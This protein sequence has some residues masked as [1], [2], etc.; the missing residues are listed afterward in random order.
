MKTTLYL[1]RHGKTEA[2]EKHVYCGWTDLPLSE[3]GREETRRMKEEGKYDF[4][5]DIIYTSGMKRT[6]ETAGI[7]F[8]GREFRVETDLMEMNFGAYE[9][10]GYEELKEV[11][12][13]IAWIEDEEG[14]VPCEDGEST[15]EFYARCNACIMRILSDL[16]FEDREEAKVAVVAH[17]GTINGFVTK[18]VDPSLGFYDAMLSPSEGYIIDI[19]LDDEGF[20]IKNYTRIQNSLKG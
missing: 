9:M 6:N 12:S 3:T 17:G 10:R 8:P 15:G 4:V 1:I 5:P 7:V 11:P 16:A 2:T 19:E 20:R 18:Y 13:Y 14:K